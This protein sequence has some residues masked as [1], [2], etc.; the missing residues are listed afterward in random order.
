VT[1]CRAIASSASTALAGIC[2]N[3]VMAI[4][5]MRGLKARTLR[6]PQDISVVGVDNTF[7]PTLSRHG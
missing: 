5:L 7:A 6:I 1:H 3:D 4:G 2:Y